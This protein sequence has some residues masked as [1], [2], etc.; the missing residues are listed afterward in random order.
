M[1]SI[2]KYVKHNKKINVAGRAILLKNMPK[3]AASII[4]PSIINFTLL[5]GSNPLIKGNRIRGFIIL[6]CIKSVVKK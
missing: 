5:I 1:S 2:Q 4:Y 6:F 3:F